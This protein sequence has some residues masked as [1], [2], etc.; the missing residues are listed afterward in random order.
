M[1][2]EGAAGSRIELGL[3]ILSNLGPTSALETVIELVRVGEAGVA[4]EEA[5]F[6]VV[7]V[8]EPANCVVGS[9]FLCGRP[10]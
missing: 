9:A 10:S 5:L 2:V 3:C 4:D 1:A 7:A 6:V 8:D